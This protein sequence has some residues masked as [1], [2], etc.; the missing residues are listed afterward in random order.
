MIS[1][2]KYLCKTF[3][4]C[5]ASTQSKIIITIYSELLWAEGLRGHFEVC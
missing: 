2:Y 3:S 1:T 4:L 5:C